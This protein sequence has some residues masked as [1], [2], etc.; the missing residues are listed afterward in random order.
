MNSRS[1]TPRLRVTRETLVFVVLLGVHVLPL[2]IFQFVPTQ[3]G[4]AH[5]SISSILR[6][7]GTPG[8][9]Y[10]RDY[11][12]LQK[13][14]FPNWFIYVMMGKVLGFLPIPLAEKVLLS[15][16]VVLLPL[17]FRYALGAVDRQATLFATFSL[18][19]VYGYHF[20]MGFYNFCFGIAGF[21]LALGWWLRHR[22]RLGVA[23]TIVLALL[24]L[25]VYFCHPVPL[26]LLAISVVTLAGWWMLLDLKRKGS[27]SFRSIGE[28]FGQYLAAPLLV[29]V[30][31]LL[32]LGAFLGSGKGTVFP[33]LRG[34]SFDLVTL[35]ALVSLD[36]RAIAVTCL[37]AALVAVVAVRTLLLRV[38]QRHVV[39]EDGLAVLAVV[40]IA[41]YF[42]AP[43]E[44]GSGLH[45]LSRISLFPWLILIMWCSAFAR[46]AIPLTASASVLALALLGLVS[47]RWAALDDRLAEYTSAA[48]R[49]EPR[50]TLLALSFANA[51]RRPDGGELSDR[52]QPF[53][54]ASGHIT[55]R[56][57]AVDFCNYVGGEDVFP[58]TLHPDRSPYIHFDQA[59]LEAEPP[60]VEF[61]SYSSRTGRTVDYV[62]LWWVD[63]SPPNHPALTSVRHQ[64][65]GYDRI[66]VSPNR[67]VQLFRRKGLSS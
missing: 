1:G 11:F 48:S 39:P 32:L 57:R 30:P 3:D 28:A 43:S 31:A 5:Q 63:A 46:R 58:I 45:V 33:S 14:A 27:P 40:L 12:V 19:F 22:E 41:V 37:L 20:W 8:G 29:L 35:R 10:L 25:G 50:R 2:W 67:L 4:P 15:A 59:D 49:I 24:V 56:S 62:L 9:A 64:L 53:V 38:R 16:Y 7:I 61:A 52:T 6:E 42:L 54:H 60:R 65:A 13:E 26:V 23:R 36:D 18:P 55:V 47:V 21:F 17:S 34:R 44:V 66:Y 51:G